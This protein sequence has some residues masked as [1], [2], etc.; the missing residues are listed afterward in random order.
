MK[1]E[2]LL[3]PKTISAEEGHYLLRDVCV[4]TDDAYHSDINEIISADLDSLT[5]SPGDD[6]TILLH[7]VD[8]ENE[9]ITLRVFN[10]EN[11]TVGYV[12]IGGTCLSNER[13]YYVTQHI[14]NIFRQR[15][16]KNATFYFYSLKSY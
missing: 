2:M 15:G 5:T 6:I 3:M 7:D 14:A 1:L 11:E 13:K 12:T 8:N 10:V 16:A 9:T 4:S